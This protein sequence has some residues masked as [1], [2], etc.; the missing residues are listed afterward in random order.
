MQFVSLKAVGQGVS[1]TP[2][3]P[4]RIT[5]RR[6]TPPPAAARKAYFGPDHGWLE[7]PV[8]PRAALGDG[9]QTGPLIVEEYDCTTVI[10]PG[11]SARLDGWSNIVIERKE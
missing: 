7:T 2:R 5:L 3:L 9:P 11:W 10:R 6:V 8:V 4:D 1:D